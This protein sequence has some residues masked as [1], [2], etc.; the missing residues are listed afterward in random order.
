MPMFG[1][2][3]GGKKEKGATSSKKKEKKKK[4]IHAILEKLEPQ[5]FFH[6]IED[7]Q[8]DALK[9]LNAFIITKENMFKAIDAGMLDTV[10]NLVKLAN[11]YHLLPVPHAR[12]MEMT[13]TLVAI[14]SLKIRFGVEANL[15][16]VLVGEI[17]EL[18]DGI[19]SSVK[20]AEERVRQDKREE[21]LKVRERVGGV[22]S[23]PRV[24][25]MTVTFISGTQPIGITVGVPPLNP[26]GGVIEV[27][28][29]G[30]QGSGVGEAE[31]KLVAEEDKQE[32]LLLEDEKAR[33]EE[34]YT[35]TEII[36]EDRK[37]RAIKQKRLLRN[38]LEEQLASKDSPQLKVGDEI[39]K[40]GKRDVQHRTNFQIQKLLAKAKRPVQVYF[41]GLRVLEHLKGIYWGAERERI[42]ELMKV[43]K[44]EAFNRRREEKQKQN[45]KEERTNEIK[46]L[47]AERKKKRKED[48]ALQEKVGMDY[49]YEVVFGAGSL[50]MALR[51][52]KNGGLGVLVQSI[53]PGGQ[54][55]KNG[56]VKVGHRP[57][58]IG[59][60][61]VTKMK[62][63]DI[64]KLIGKSKRPLTMKLKGREQ[65]REHGEAYKVIFYTGPMGVKLVERTGKGPLGDGISVGHVQQNGYAERTSEI[66]IGDIINTFGPMDPKHGPMED[67]RHFRLS[68][69]LKKIKETKRPIVVE[70]LTPDIETELIAAAEFEQAEAAR[71]AEEARIKKEPTY[72]VVLTRKP[73]GLVLEPFILPGPKDKKIVVAGARIK[74]VLARSEANDLKPR[75][76]RAGDKLVNING[77][78]VGKRPLSFVNNL[79][80]SSKFPMTL[81]LHR[82][83]LQ[84][85]QE[86]E[87]IPLGPLEK[88]FLVEEPET[89]LEHTNIDEDYHVGMGLGRIQGARLGAKVEAVADK[90]DAKNIG[91]Q[92][93]WNLVRVATIDVRQMD[94]K[95]IKDVLNNAVRPYVLDFDVVTLK[96]KQ[97][98]SSTA[99]AAGAGGSGESKSKDKTPNAAV[100]AGAGAGS[101]KKG[102]LLSKLKSA[103]GGGRVAKGKVNLR[104]LLWSAAPKALP[105]PN[106]TTDGEGMVELIPEYAKPLA[107]LITNG[108][109][110]QVTAS[111]DTFATLANVLKMFFKVKS[112]SE[113]L[114]RPSILK[115]CTLLTDSPAGLQ[116]FIGVNK[117][118]ATWIGFLWESKD[119]PNVLYDLIVQLHR[120]ALSPNIEQH[121]EY[122]SM[123]VARS[124]VNM[125]NA[126]HG[127]LIR[128]KSGAGMESYLR[129]LEIMLHIIEEPQRLKLVLNSYYQKPGLPGLWNMLSKCRKAPVLQRTMRFLR[130]VTIDRDGI[131]Y[132]SYTKGL[133]PAST[134]E[135]PANVLNMLIMAMNRAKLNHGGF[136]YEYE[137]QPGPIGLRLD[138]APGKRSGTVVKGV[139]KDGQADRAGI[140]EPGDILL[141]IGKKNVERFPLDRAMD[142]LRSAPRP[143]TM[144]FRKPN[145]NDGAVADHAKYQVRFDSGPV[146]LKLV[147]LADEEPGARIQFIEPGTQAALHDNI[148]VGH[149][150]YAV[151]EIEVFNKKY[152]QVLKTMKQ[153]KRPVQ[154]TFMNPTS[155]APEEI[156]SDEIMFDVATVIVKVLENDQKLEEEIELNPESAADIRAFHEFHS[157]TSQDAILI[158]ELIFQRLLKRP[159]PARNFVD[160]AQ[161][162]MLMC[163]RTD[164][165]QTSSL[166]IPAFLH[167]NHLD[168]GEVQPDYDIHMIQGTVINVTKLIDE[169]PEIAVRVARAGAL[170]TALRSFNRLQ[171]AAEKGE[172]G[173]LSTLENEVIRWNK[174]MTDLLEE[175]IPHRNDVLSAIIQDTAPSLIANLFL[176]A[177]WCETVSHHELD[178]LHAF[179]EHADVD[180][181]GKFNVETD[182]PAFAEEIRCC[183]ERIQLIKLMEAQIYGIIFE[184][185]RVHKS[186]SKEV[187]DPKFLPSVMDAMVRDWKFPSFGVV[188]VPACTFYFLTLL[189]FSLKVQMTKVNSADHV[190]G[191]YAMAHLLSMITVDEQHVVL[192]FTP[193]G[194][195]TLCTT[196]LAAFEYILET[197]TVYWHG[198]GLSEHI[199]AE[200]HGGQEQATIACIAQVLVQVLRVVDIKEDLDP[201]S[202]RTLSLP[203]LHSV[204]KLLNRTVRQASMVFVGNKHSE[205]NPEFMAY[206]RCQQSLVLVL[207]EFS[208][209]ISFR[210][211]MSKLNVPRACLDVLVNGR[212]LDSDT[213]VACAGTTY[214][215]MLDTKARQICQ[216]FTKHSVLYDMCLMFHTEYATSM[217]MKALLLASVRSIVDS[218]R[219]SA[220]EAAGNM[221]HLIPVLIDLQELAAK[222]PAQTMR[223]NGK[224][225]QRSQND[226]MTLTAATEARELIRILTHVQYGALRSCREAVVTGRKH[227]AAGTMSLATLK[228]LHKRRMKKIQTERGWQDPL[229]AKGKKKH[230]GRVIED[231][232]ALE[233]DEE[234]L[235]DGELGGDALERRLELTFDQYGD[236]I[237][238]GSVF[239]NEA[240][241][242]RNLDGTM[243]NSTTGSGDLDMENVRGKCV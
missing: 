43:E 159:V 33:I 201:K 71:K 237:T 66:H 7:K 114:V 127:T 216:D 32:L 128:D 231:E 48:Q 138:V 79:L 81:V 203:L 152:S 182:N 87:L 158:L 145:M 72:K 163:A 76:V 30:S 176:V 41:K 130:L 53:A 213:M 156:R 137:F 198:L 226:Q 97:A 161:Q 160:I 24:V 92:R 172:D 84:K 57:I 49:M 37:I 164:Y 9:G 242:N 167:L 73:H 117:L 2:L 111:G 132:S 211:A 19:L 218:T 77:K 38:R 47:K 51:A 65:L 54:A 235:Y 18:V 61:L 27:L 178:R 62:V 239:K 113:N 220:V 141:Q 15:C 105:Q 1:G 8:L 10:T 240:M 212:G 68:H 215:I 89:G 195:L 102:G 12:I 169:C 153:S 150:M 209:M 168:V 147:H 70:F 196:T 223:K 166:Y 60:Q 16:N 121:A 230:L 126:T 143:V 106:L 80:R 11:D 64:I 206:T 55:A 144:E 115:M 78:K 155:R 6:V 109:C 39:L 23:R 124:V 112:R 162:A 20:E 52:P 134:G 187:M 104:S 123:F 221:R 3:F 91:I 88:R 142:E 228:S 136:E 98:S 197:E 86:A 170:G 40:I 50:G 208:T 154:V 173:E 190:K 116:A 108:V 120:I 45:K 180:G 191:L 85:V 90:G 122:Q 222:V 129:L 133:R 151:G 131:L 46:R 67:V 63:K 232:N 17:Q 119:S 165:V 148:Q 75:R 233:E 202:T 207:Y 192:L 13:Q 103:K 236:I 188:R 58:R 14:P 200:K 101:A 224:V 26:A 210:P 204:V 234:E 205:L 107:E 69:L 29:Y 185:C 31:W 34:D 179:I 157:L 5:E 83:S 22:S 21:Q 183:E 28:K 25:T 100:G 171:V 186:C 93:D 44:D 194:A 214:N 36:E 225:R 42:E 227:Y 94:L 181:D 177:M 193:P 146:G 219:L 82:E 99:G 175:V 135:P 110:K 96:N 243:R 4:G 74:H 140:I 149:V 241:R 35:E 139:S 238:D 174:S 199:V 56:A 125:L 217:H 189:F 184:G 118:V 95:A 59:E 229:H